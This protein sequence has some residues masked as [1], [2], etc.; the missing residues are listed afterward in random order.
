MVHRLVC[1]ADAVARCVPRAAGDEDESAGTGPDRKVLEFLRILDEYRLKCEEEGNYMEASRAA[2]QLDT[3]RKQE[4][5]RQ[6][7]GLR[8]RQLGERQNLHAAHNLQY[9]EFNKAWDAYMEEFDRMAQ[10]YIE[11]VR[12]CCREALPV[13][14]YPRLLC[15]CVCAWVWVCACVCV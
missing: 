15:V 12:R 14:V 5:K 2:K 3:L 6:E 8:S 1:A 10:M 7:K 11:Q 13:C 9:A 4:A